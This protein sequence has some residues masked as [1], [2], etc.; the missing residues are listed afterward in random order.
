MNDLARHLADLI[1]ARGPISVAHYMAEALG[2]PRW[3]YYMNRDPFGQRGDFVTAP[4]VSQ[5]F[6]ELIGLWCA[7]VWEAMG[8]PDPVHLVEIG[9]GRGTL[10]ADALRAGAT[11]P[12][13]RAALRVHLIE[14]SPFLRER[15]R[16]TLTGVGPIWHDSF[17][18]VPRGPILVIAN[19][20]FDA[21]PV[22]QFQRAADGWH[23]R[24]VDLDSADDRFRLVLAPTRCDGLVPPSLRNAPPGSVAEVCP[25]GLAL[26]EALAARFD[27]DRGAALVID[28]G[29][30]ETGPGETLQAVRA[31]ARHDVFREPGAA[32]ICAHVD[33]AQLVAVLESKGVGIYGPIEQG[34]FLDNLGL[35]VRAAMLKR[36]AA[37]EDALD[38]D[39]AVERLT[40]TDQ[41][42]RLFKVL[43]FADRATTEIP[44]FA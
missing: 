18:Q 8:A 15:Q 16:R 7:A 42:G 6:G 22:R 39:R 26:I 44:A 32:D 10:M 27:Q 31:H 28:Y 34:R 5:M 2:H 36:R 33:F 4:E 19:E 29:V 21:L 25:A 11:V 12:A 30:T 14:T 35:R 20:L 23:E 40:G 38:V 9:P 3:G 1:R 13:F 43:A 24:L 37:S 17:E 41:M